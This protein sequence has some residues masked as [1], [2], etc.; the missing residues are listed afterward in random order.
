MGSLRGRETQ[1]SDIYFGITC[2]RINFIFE[3]KR[4]STSIG[5][6]PRDKKKRRVQKQTKA[7]IYN[8]VKNAR[9]YK[10]FDQS[11]ITS[12]PAAGAALLGAMQG[13]SAGVGQNQ[14]VGSTLKL[15]SWTLRFNIIGADG[16]NTIRLICG[17]WVTSSVPTLAL[18]LETPTN[19]LT[20]FQH[21]HLDDMVIHRDMV[22][23]TGNTI[24]GTPGAGLLE[25]N[26]GKWYFPSKKL[27][28]VNFQGAALSDGQPFI[29]A[30]SDSLVATD[31]SLIWYSRIIFDDTY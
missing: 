9:A 17:Q 8:R 21:E 23:A 30:M 20:P 26:S 6:A 2:V 29:I 10:Y 22:T 12:L 27:V 7:Q 14:Y 24:T 19:A 13:I 15:V 11:G 25:R 28:H 31:P 5:R 3:M 18:I 16:Y 1:P 4:S